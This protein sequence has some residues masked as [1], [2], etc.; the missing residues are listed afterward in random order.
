ML[1]LDALYMLLTLIPGP[2]E[3]TFVHKDINTPT[4]MQKSD[5]YADSTEVSGSKQ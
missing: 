5:K 2:F 1:P 4:V 3:L